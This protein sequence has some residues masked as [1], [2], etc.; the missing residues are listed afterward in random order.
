MSVMSITIEI[1][2]I[3]ATPASSRVVCGRK[4]VTFL[5]SKV[6]M[7]SR[8]RVVVDVAGVD[9]CGDDDDGRRRAYAH[10]QVDADGVDTAESGQRRELRTREDVAVRVV[11]R[12]D[13]LARVEIAT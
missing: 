1:A 4:R 2:M 10:P 11:E 13:R 6:I 7:A 5:R 3:I 8:V 12:E 9:Q